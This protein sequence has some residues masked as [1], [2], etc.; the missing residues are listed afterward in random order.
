MDQPDS[1]PRPFPIKLI[2]IINGIGFVVTL[3]FR[4]F[5]F[6][7]SLAPLPDNLTVAAER[8]NAATTYG[9]MIGD[10][11]WSVPLLL[12]GSI[13]LWRLQ[14]LGWTAAQM[15]N[16]LWVYSMTVVWTR[17]VYTSFS[18]GGMLFIPFTLA[19]PWAT[20]YLWKYRDLFWHHIEH[21]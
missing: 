13:S 18:P 3:V 21:E 19:A 9:F 10:M 4:A 5:V 17:D 1:T 20:V 12:I 7:K 14:P 6:F 2:A 16:I 11:L 15:V 8:A